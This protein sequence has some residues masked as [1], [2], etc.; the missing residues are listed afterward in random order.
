[1]RRRIKPLVLRRTRA[2]VAPELPPK[3]EQVL[4]RE[5]QK[6]LG[7]LG[8]WEKNRFQIF[9]SLTLLRQMSL[10]VGMVDESKM[11]VGSA[12]IDFLVEQLPGLVAEGHRALVFSQFTHFLEIL[13]SHLDGVCVSHSY[14][15]GSLSARE[16]G[17]AIATFQG[18]AS[19]VFLISLK[20]GGFGAEPHRSR[21]LL[22]LRPVVESGRRGSGHRPDTPNR[23][24]S[25][26]RISARFRDRS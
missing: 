15:D 12:K 17:A 11:D 4:A 16:R 13:R 7:L 21:L 9:R 1:L 26:R 25:P 8:E 24:P 22:R 19:Q 23:Q 2:Q 14:L 18:G 5:R 6:V 20:A 3:Q 10:H